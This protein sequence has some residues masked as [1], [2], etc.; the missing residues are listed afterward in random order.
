[1]EKGGYI[2]ILSTRNDALIYIGVTSNLQ[3]RLSEHK[4]KKFPGFAKTYC[5]QKLVYYEAYNTITEAIAR[6]KQLKRWS[7]AKKNCLIERM[8]PNWIDMSD[9]G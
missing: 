6:E 4:D 7:R 3:K 1:M 5:V 2:Y 8:N 9:G